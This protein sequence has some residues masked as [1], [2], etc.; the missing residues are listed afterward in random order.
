MSF[1]I[2]DLVSYICIYGL[3]IPN[4]VIFTYKSYAKDIHT[5]G[6]VID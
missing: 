5:R 2:A 3:N 1:Y 6:L 4:R